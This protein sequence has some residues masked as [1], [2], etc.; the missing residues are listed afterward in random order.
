[1]S[2]TRV[3]VADRMRK[4]SKLNQKLFDEYFKSQLE[5]GKNINTVRSGLSKVLEAADHKDVNLLEFEDLRTAFIKMQTKI[6][7]PTVNARIEYLKTFLKFSA[8]KITLQFD[9]NDLDKLKIDQS[10]VEANKENMWKALSFDEVIALRLKLREVKLYKSLYYF[11]MFYAL[12]L[13]TDLLMN[14][15]R[16]NYVENE[17]K[18]RFQSVEYPLP[19]Q[20]HDIPH[21]KIIPNRQLNNTTPFYHLNK[22]EAIFSRKVTIG[23]I[24]ATRNQTFFKCPKC[25]DMYEANPENWVVFH[26]EVDDSKWI[27]CRKKCLGEGVK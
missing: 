23:D 6:K 22:I 9:I 18:F 20:L 26:Y 19:L 4:S 2:G 17:K 25:G 8:E 12:G 24:I 21:D 3:A 7:P 16:G 11:E 15:Q 14:L 1:M 13:E 10:E 27:V 5:Q